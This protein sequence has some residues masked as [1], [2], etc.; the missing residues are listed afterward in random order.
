MDLNPSRQDLSDLR[1]FP[2]EKA[3]TDAAVRAEVAGHGDELV[4][5]SLSFQ[6][7]FGAHRAAYRLKEYHA[8]RWRLF[9]R[10]NNPF[11]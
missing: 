11:D 1:F 7:F 8:I 6:Q 4:R 9:I 10:H 2:A 3:D 5:Y